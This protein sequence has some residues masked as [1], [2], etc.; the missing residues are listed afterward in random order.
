MGKGEEWETI[1]FVRRRLY[2]DEEVDD[3]D[4]QVRADGGYIFVWWKINEMSASIFFFNG[5]GK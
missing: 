1:C 4:W 5:G 3:D 2:F